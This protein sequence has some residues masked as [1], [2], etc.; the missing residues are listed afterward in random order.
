MLKEIVI[1]V[2]DHQWYD[3]PYLLI[4]LFLCNLFNDAVNRAEYVAWNEWKKQRVVKSF[5]LFKNIVTYM[6]YVAN[7]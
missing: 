3:L 5:S 1:N 6:D 4:Y 7:N 2:T